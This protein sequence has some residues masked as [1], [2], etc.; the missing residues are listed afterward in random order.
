[1]GYAI[2]LSTKEFTGSFLDFLAL[3]IGNYRLLG[4]GPL[5]FLEVLLI[6]DGAYV[7]WRRWVKSANIESKIPETKL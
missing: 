5:W 6:F 3:Y 4:S 7:L 2:A 1:M